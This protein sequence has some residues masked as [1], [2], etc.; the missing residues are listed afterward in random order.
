MSSIY[1]ILDHWAGG[2]VWCPSSI[3][4]GSRASLIEPS[5]EFTTLVGQI[6]HD[7]LRSGQ[8]SQAG[9]NRSLY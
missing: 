9:E 5:G 8:E 7:L 2:D 3:T 4:E 1:S 6:G